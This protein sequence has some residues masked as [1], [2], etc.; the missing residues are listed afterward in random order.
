MGKILKSTEYK[1][2]IDLKTRV[3]AEET[4][5]YFESSGSSMIVSKDILDS[6]DKAKQILEEARTQANEVKKEA[7]AILNQVQEE[8]EKARKKGEEE[9][10]QEGLQQ[11]LEYLHQIHLLREKMF[12]DIEPQV[13]KLTFSIAE[14][15]IG[16]QVHQNE[17][18]IYEIVRQALDAALG[19]KISIR[20]NPEDYAQVKKNESILLSRVDSSKTVSFKEDESIQQG[21]CIV[22]SE[23][24]AI[25]AQL[26]TQLNAIKKA[27]GL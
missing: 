3:E 9:G 20:L 15:V 21:G 18:A 1:S 14:K 16:Q 5:Q 13:V 12:S 22:E 11:A 24:G 2:K 26:N 6:Q 27:L 23:V 10:Y 25:D 4:P 19:H 8:M 7:K 17:T